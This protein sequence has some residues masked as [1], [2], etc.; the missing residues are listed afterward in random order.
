M[1]GLN[2]GETGDLSPK[3]VAAAAGEK[4]K[5]EVATF[6]AA[7]QEKVSSEVEEKTAQARQTLG[8][9]AAA[10]RRAGDDLSEHD[11]SVAGRVV[12]QA[13]DGLENLARSLTD[14]RPEQLLDAAREFGR[15]NPTAFIVGG[16]LLGIAAG[17]FLRSSAPDEAT[18]GVERQSYSPQP[19]AYGADDPSR[20]PAPPIDARDS[21]MAVAG[22]AGLDD[23]FDA[24]AD[25]LNQGERRPPFT[26]GV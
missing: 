1:S 15:R 4:V 25:P 16:I 2:F 13:A 10:V 14:K 9:F 20:D 24:Q 7:A 17:R 22:S 11:Q 6:A 19:L 12:K 5:E 18:A 3:E 21:T 23:P 8:D 26:P